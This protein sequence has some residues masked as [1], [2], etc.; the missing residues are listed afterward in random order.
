MSKGLYGVGSLL[1]LAFP[2][3]YTVTIGQL[4]LPW[5]EQESFLI[6][7][8]RKDLSFLGLLELCILEFWNV[9]ASLMS[10]D[11]WQIEMR[12]WTE[13]S[14]MKGL[15]TEVWWPNKGCWGAQGLAQHGAATVKGSRG[16]RRAGRV[17][18]TQPQLER[19]EGWLE[20]WSGVREGSTARPRPC[21]PHVSTPHRSTED[22][23][24]G[25]WMLGA[26]GAMCSLSGP[27]AGWCV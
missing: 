19:W 17:R 14:Q 23:Q 24:P 6:W 9:W 7:T 1:T 27:R 26:R 21:S 25:S 3:N 15:V 8:T 5:S 16:T 11:T 13:E 18:G 22:R 2:V 4:L 10:G 12:V 20:P